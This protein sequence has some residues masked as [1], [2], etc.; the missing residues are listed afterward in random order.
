MPRN[1][2]SSNSRL[3]IIG[4]LV[5]ALTT[6]IY[7][8]SFTRVQQLPPTA[9]RTLPTPPPEATVDFK[10]G[11]VDLE[12]LEQVN[13]LD[14]RFERDGLVLEDDATNAY[15]KRI[16]EVLVPRD[17]KLENIV[18]KFR[19]LR[20]P[21]ANAFA[22]PNG[23]IYITTGLLALLDNEAQVAAVLAHEMTH[24]LRR[25]TYLQ[26]R[27]NRKKFLTANVIELV[28][29]LT[30]GTGGLLLFDAIAL[31]S[32]I[33]LQ[34][35]IAGYG[36]DLER[37]ADLKGVELMA[38]A[39][40]PP[41]EMVKAFKLLSNDLEGEQIKFFY[42]DH[43]SYQDRIK[44]VSE[45]IGARA[46]KITPAMELNREKNAYFKRAELVMRHNVQLEINASRFR[47]ALYISRRLAEFNPD[48]SENLFW[49]AESYR[50][51]GPR[52]PELTERELTERA[53]RDAQKKRDKRTVEEEERELLATPTGQE[54]WKA[55]Q[56]KAEGFYQRALSLDTPAPVAHRGLGMLYEKVGRTNDAV[57]EY[58]KYVE[59]APTS[60][61]HERIQ[62]RIESL[63]RLTQ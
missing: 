61:D 5:L 12:L 36:R 24:V 27:S 49:L 28:A 34:A 29:G 57:T 4:L 31:I 38:N 19:A 41:E 22:L 11:K 54:N 47:S 58:E 44:Y 50:M 43:P 30:P 52:A 9:K 14:R 16:G 7:G 25:H 37:E 8:Q 18:W 23:S 15:L 32:P 21:Q 39:E 48:S 55:H 46:D 20:D 60:I 51:L 53:K 45:H 40:Y 33:I 10:F 35:M 6:P 62:K 17:L 42:N 63:R 26:N 13:L 56:E 59:L 2:S 1:M 3:V